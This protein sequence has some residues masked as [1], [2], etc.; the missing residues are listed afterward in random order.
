MAEILHHVVNEARV[1][2]V[3]VKV[4]WEKDLESRVD[5]TDLVAPVWVAALELMAVLAWALARTDLVVPVWAVGLAVQ[6]DRARLAAVQSADLQNRAAV[7]QLPHLAV[8]RHVLLAAAAV[9]HHLHLLPL[10][11]AVAGHHHLR[12]TSQNV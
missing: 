5:Q 11:M 10:A 8:E 3:V 12:T 7:E 2:K 9:G 6:V 4:I 1:N